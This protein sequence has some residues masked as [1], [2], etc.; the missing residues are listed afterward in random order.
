MISRVSEWEKKGF[1]GNPTRERTWKWIESI[2]N[3]KVSE[4]SCKDLKRIPYIGQVK[5][6][7]FFI[8]HIRISP[9]YLFYLSF[10]ISQDHRNEGK[11][12]HGPVNFLIKILWPLPSSFLRL[13]LYKEGSIQSYIESASGVYIQ[14]IFTQ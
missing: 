10:Q 12:F 11:D 14:S 1:S 7:N 2:S 3:G 8:D 6:S 4:T 9:W 13:A 5:T